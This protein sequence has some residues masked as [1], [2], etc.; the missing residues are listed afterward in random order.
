M[1]TIEGIPGGSSCAVAHF[2]TL[3]GEMPYQ[4]IAGLEFPTRTAAKAR[5]QSPANDATIADL[6]AC[7]W[8]SLAGDAILDHQSESAAFSLDTGVVL[9]RPK[10]AVMLPVGT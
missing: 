7:P 8:K 2:T 3:E 6:N 1:A 4:C 9:G 10:L 5:Q